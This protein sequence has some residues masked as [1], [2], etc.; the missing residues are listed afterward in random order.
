M[1]FYDSSA[2]S[3]RVINMKVMLDRGW[4]SRR[5]HVSMWPQKWFPVRTLTVGI[6]LAR[7]LLIATTKRTPK[8][9]IGLTPVCINPLFCR[10]SKPYIFWGRYYYPLFQKGQQLNIACVGIHAA[11]EGLLWYTFLNMMAFALNFPFNQPHQEYAIL[12]KVQPPAG[13]L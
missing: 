4:V 6:E 3:Q 12:L 9:G 8:Q 7:N 5:V 11:E 10:E 2:Q 1:D 13:L